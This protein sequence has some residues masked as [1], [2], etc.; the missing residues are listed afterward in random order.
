MATIV[1][2]DET[3]DHS[4]EK[5]DKDFPLF[6]LTMVVCD[7]E[8]YIEKIVPSVNHL[9]F[10]Y[11]GHEGVILHSREIRKAQKDFNFLLNPNE[12]QPFYERINRIMS[13]ADYRLIVTAIHK[14]DHRAKYGKNAAN[15]YDLSLTFSMEILLHLL[16]ANGDKDVYITA[17]SRGKKE[18]AELE[19]SFLRIISYGTE[20]CLP[21][22]F[23]RINLKLCFRAKQMN[24]VGMQLADLAGYP[25]ARQILNPERENPAFEVIKNKFY[26]SGNVQGLKIF[27]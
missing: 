21:D 22:R 27:P 3:G 17:E 26:Q 10:D 15:P 23:K 6:V 20:H 18:D 5:D 4:L 8:E 2:L 24:I 12:R 11:F 25:I 1:Y 14:Q 9:K 16:E 13:E 7:D 19:T